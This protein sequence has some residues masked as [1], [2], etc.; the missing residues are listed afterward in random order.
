M[1]K[2]ILIALLL[3]VLI[4]GCGSDELSFEEQLA[5]DLSAIDNYL[6]ENALDAEIHESGIRFDE[7]LQGNG[8]SPVVGE[9]AVVKYSLSILGNEE[10]VADSEFGESFTIGS[11]IP[12]ALLFMLQEM[13][14]GGKMTIYSPSVYG[15]G[16]SSNSVIPSN[17][18]LVFDLELVQVV[19]NAEEQFAADTTIIE[20]YLLANEIDAMVHESGIRFTVQAEG[21]GD[22]PGL[23]D[24][25]NVVYQGRFLNERVFDQSTD[26][27][28][29]PLAN[30]I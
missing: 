15:F 10:V 28:S 1:V 30:L 14:E 7:T 20:S 24:V 3:P 17:S 4:V 6:E 21:T 19:R 9:V 8:R 22:S 25:V 13:Q 16:P 26:G 5:L 29:F 27:I 18:N 11:G 2:N 12:Q 23:S